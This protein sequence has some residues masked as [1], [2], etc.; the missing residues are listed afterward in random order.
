MRGISKLG[1]ILVFGVLVLLSGALADTHIISNT[2]NWKD[3]YSSMLYA[4]LN[5]YQGNFL[6]ST[7]HGPLL[8]TGIP[9]VNDVVIQSSEDNPF[10]FN[11]RSTVAA[12]GY[13][14]VEEFEYG[15]FN[16]ELLD[17]LDDVEN[18]IIVDGSY[19]YSAIAV[20]PYAVLTNSWVFFADRVNIAE[21]ENAMARRNVGDVLIYGYTDREVGEAM[22][23]YNPR[24]INTGNRFADNIEI[25]EEYKK[26]EDAKQVL[27]S[28][29]EFIERELMSGSHPVLFTGRE[30]VPDEIAEYLQ[31][32]D[33][34]VG[35]LIGNEL[36]NAATNIRRSAGISVMVKFAQG[37]RAQQSGVSAVE[38]L[39]LFYLPTPSL[40]LE[41]S[42]VKYNRA[43]E[44]IEVTYHSTSNVPIYLQGTLTVVSDNGNE[45]AGD[46]EAIFI[47]PSDY[48]TITYPDMKFNGNDLT[49][50]LYTLFG[51]V[52][53]SFDRELQGSFKMEV[54]DV[55]DDCEIEVNFVK[56]NKQKEIFIVGI[57]NVGES[58]CY[59]D[60]ELED[61]E[62]NGVTQTIGSEGSSFLKSGKSGKIEFDQRMDES[63]LRDNKLVDLVVYYGEREDSLVK[64]FRGKF[65]LDIDMFSG[66]VYLIV[67]V[68][69]LLILLLVILWKKKRDDEW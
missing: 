15:D 11:Y 28:N 40:N 41:V 34:E 35:V 22:A 43:A 44:Q 42:S 38:G 32:S 49:V 56:Y 68:L 18:F 57:D 66:A 23:Q 39:D 19:G 36:I 55:I 31:G 27:L 7:Q 59:I 6:A 30:N 65:D 5:E 14:S 3:V 21:I 10:V 8:L 12:R 46:E 1:L 58:D 16:L 69:I 9:A 54:I 26:L 45:R 53:G 47:A 52:K 33:I 2:E 63:D 29:G 51:E 64:V 4:S 37:A 20:T 17:E 67:V 48:K 24:I 60:V 61:V 62:I 25:V 50:E 13:N